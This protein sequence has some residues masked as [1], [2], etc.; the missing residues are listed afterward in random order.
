MPFSKNRLTALV[1][2]LVLALALP[3]SVAQAAKA[4]KV[5]LNT[6]TQD[7]L[8]ALPGVGAAYAKKII[9][10]RPYASV[11]DLSKAGLP[12][13]TVDKISSLVTVSKSK[14]K[15][16]KTSEKAEKS[17]KSSASEKPAKA[18]KPAAAE[19][20]SASK[21]SKSSSSSS[22]GPVDLNTASERELEE[23]PGVGPATAKKIVAG[24]PYASVSDLSKAGVPASTISK[25]SSMVV[26]G[27]AAKS[28]ASSS[29]SSRSASTEKS[30]PASSASAPASSASSRSSQ[31]SE[32]TVPARQAPAKGM[33]WVNTATKVYHFEGDPW[34]GKTKE[35]KFMTEQDAIKAGYRASKEGAPK[36]Q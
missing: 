13:S 22:S 14:A 23:L 7:E 5:D 29:S 24:R 2:L 17:E 18:E 32:Q 6:A 27:G 34:Y 33:V 28:T 25:I 26:V 9:D 16:E 11:A 8:E 19:S 20:S 30:A 31:A 35:G 3:A 10:G 12:A 1:A 15:S 4:K 36:S 21:S